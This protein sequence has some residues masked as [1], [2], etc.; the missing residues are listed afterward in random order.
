MLEYPSVNKNLNLTNNFLTFDAQKNNFKDIRVSKQEAVVNKLKGFNISPSFI[1]TYRTCSLRFYFDYVLKLKN[2]EKKDNLTDP[3]I[4]GTIFHETLE[5]LYQG[6]KFVDEKVI[7]ELKS[8][9]KDILT[10][11]SKK[12]LEEINTGYGKLIYNILDKTISNFLKTDSKTPFKIIKL[13][14]KLE[15]KFNISVDDAIEQSYVL[16]LKGAV[17]RI[18]MIKINDED[19]VRIIDYKTGKSTDFKQ[20]KAIDSSINS[21]SLQLLHYAYCYNTDKNFKSSAFFVMDRSKIQ[22]DLLINKQTIIDKDIKEEIFLQF[23]KLLLEIFNEIFNIE[24]PFTQTEDEKSCNVCL[25]SDICG[26]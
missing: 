26:R 23:E 21:I 22:R 9:Y 13:E 25:Y 14:E 17:D 18:D 8:T 7:I 19:I 12:Y 11:V 20:V 2:F 4:F 10:L 5:E 1:N 3:R 24:T 15:R 6:I 16:N